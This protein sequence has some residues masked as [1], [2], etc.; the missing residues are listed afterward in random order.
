VIKHLNRINRRRAIQIIG[1][2]SGTLGSILLGRAF[3]Q[4]SSKPQTTPL[5]AS[6]LTPVE[7]ETATVNE[8]GD[9]T[10]GT[11]KSEIF[12]EK[13]GE[14]SLDLMPIEGGTFVMGSPEGESDNNNEEPQHEV[15]I[16]PFLMGQYLITQAQWRAVAALEKVKQDLEADP[17]H[18]KGDNLP[19]ENVTWYEAVEFCERL[20][21]LT[22]Q[23]Y[24]LPSEAEWEYACRAGTTTR[25]H[26]GEVLKATLANY[27]ATQTIGS[28]AEREFREKTTKVGSFPANAFGLHDM[29]GN[30]VEWCE[31]HWHYDYEG[32]PT[33][34][35][36][37]LSSSEKRPRLLRGGSWVSTPPICR[38]A[39]RIYSSP[40]DRDRSTGFRVSCS[41]PQT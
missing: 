1:L 2:A 35:S 12:K 13:I 29:H 5:T 37:W 41:I 15:T 30:V 36:A 18:F 38:A 21:R 31:D 8:K 34:G 28:V 22:G 17:S 27:D 10:R 39:Q 14:I 32:A 4:R 3:L 7:F 25:F 19:V 9:I 16:L 20:S 24:R 40:D 23:T 6:D 26:F 11:G 33:D